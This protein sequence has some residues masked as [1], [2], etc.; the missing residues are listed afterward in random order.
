MPPMTPEARQQ[1]LAATRPAAQAFLEDITYFRDILIRKDITQPEIRRLSAELRR[2]LIDN[3]GDLEKI[4]APRI[5]RIRLHEPDNQ[6]M[7]VAERKSNY[8]F[9]QSGGCPIQGVSYRAVYVRT[10]PYG[11]HQLHSD[12]PREIK[13]DG[14]LSQRVIFFEHQWVTRRDVIKYVANVA[15]GVHSGVATETSEK[16]LARIRNVYTFSVEYRPDGTKNIVPAL[17]LNALIN[18]ELPFKYTPTSI[19]A[20]LAELL[21]AI[22]F[23]VT[24]TDVIKLEAEIRTELQEMA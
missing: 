1:L 16:L 17:N 8:L 14:F 23:L 7:Y 18:E 15:Q 21:A 12:I 4:A 6:P 2:I 9:F 19:D 11:S 3:G 10:P 5:G 13:L 22:H 20:V 24:S